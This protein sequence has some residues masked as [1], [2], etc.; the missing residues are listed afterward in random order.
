MRRWRSPGRPVAGFLRRIGPGRRRSISQVRA[1]NSACFPMWQSSKGTPQSVEQHRI[2]ELGRS[3]ASTLRARPRNRYG[4]CDMFSIPPATT[5]RASPSR[6]ACEASMTALSPDPQTLLMVSAATVGGKPAFSA[7]CRAG[8]CPTP[9]ERIIPMMTS[10]TSR[11]CRPARSRAAR[12]TIDPSSGSRDPLQGPQK[13]ANR[14]PG[15]GEEKGIGHDC[16]P[17]KTTNDI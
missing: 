3:R 17:R 2:F 9:A 5:T 12:M 14:R 13:F 4:A 6:T 11:K 7:A 16:T 10:S 1:V 15:P 8:A